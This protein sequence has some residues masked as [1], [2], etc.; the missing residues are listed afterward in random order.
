MTIFKNGWKL[1]IFI[2]Q[3]LLNIYINKDWSDKHM[4]KRKITIL[5]IS[6]GMIMLAG[7]EKGDSNLKSSDMYAAHLIGETETERQD[8]V[9]EE[10]QSSDHAEMREYMTVLQDIVQEALQ[11]TADFYSEIES[12]NI[13]SGLD[14]DT[15]AGQSYGEVIENADTPYIEINGNVPYFKD[16]EYTTETYYKL[17]ELDELGRCGQ[18]EGCF[19]RETIAEGERGSIGHIKPSGWHTVKYPEIVNGNYLYNRCHMLMWKL[20]GI[21]DDERN[22]ITGTRYMNVEGMLPFEEKMVNYVQNTGNHVLYRV[23][24][25][26]Q[27]K[28]LVAR[29]VYME[30]L[31]MEDN[32]E[33]ITFNV[34]CYNIQPE[35]TIDYMTGESW[36]TLPIK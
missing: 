27:D 29:G 6:T 24:P 35:I 30:A 23:T 11:E 26:F 12:E 19:G 22:L 15:G 18:A 25:D 13:L 17:S 3:S 31:S 16:Y 32:G 34:Y 33:G 9:A 10:Q 28:E 36:E 2:D 21:L 1:L 8:T 20:S 5:L 7:C 14:G 4:K